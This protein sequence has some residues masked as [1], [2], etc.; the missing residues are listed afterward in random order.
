M[1]IWVDIANPPQVLF[2]RP[3]IAELTK[4]GHRLIVTTRRHSESISL[5]DRYGLSHKVIG[6]HGGGT[7]IGKGA[8]IVSRA[9][10]SVWY[11]RRQGI[12]LAVGSSS[13]S[14][15][16]AAKWMNIPYLP[17]A[18]TQNRSLQ[19]QWDYLFRME[20]L[21]GMILLQNIFP[22]SNCMIRTPHK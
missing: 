6:V 10:S 1:N 2:L 14:Q 11:L 16:I 22:T 15:A 9:L 4:R 19:Q 17:S 8:A 12:S 13:Y 7:L 5:A 21:R 18:R 20:N 3:I